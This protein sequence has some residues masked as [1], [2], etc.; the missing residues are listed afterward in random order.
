MKGMEPPLPG[1]KQEQD[2]FRVFSEMLNNSHPNPERNGCVDKSLLWK[3]VCRPRAFR[4]DEHAE[5]TLKHLGECS[6]CGK[7]LGKIVQEAKAKKR[8]ARNSFLRRKLCGIMA[9][10]KA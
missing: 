6:V 9:R 1:S 2:F 5:Y 4:S 10:M 3:L 7:E 8:I